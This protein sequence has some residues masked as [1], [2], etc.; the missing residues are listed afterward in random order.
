MTP[1]R[2]RSTHQFSFAQLDR[3]EDAE[4]EYLFFILTEFLLPIENYEILSDFDFAK[5][6]CFAE[7]C[8]IFNFPLFLGF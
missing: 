7:V 2:I 8:E 1:A 3:V 6:E 4:H 5:N